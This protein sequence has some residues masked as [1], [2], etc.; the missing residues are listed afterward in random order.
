MPARGPPRPRDSPTLGALQFPVLGRTGSAA[1]FAASALPSP[2][3]A[4]Q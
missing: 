3:R 4:P 1:G 2:R